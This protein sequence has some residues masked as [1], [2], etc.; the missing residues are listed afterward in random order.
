MSSL[1]PVSQYPLPPSY[2]LQVGS[3]EI[4]PPAPPQGGDVN[5]VLAFSGSIPRSKLVVDQSDTSYR[6]V[7][8]R[9]GSISNFVKIPF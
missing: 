4:A 3:E 9:F 2:C 7:L 6:D 8:K 5:E 1:I